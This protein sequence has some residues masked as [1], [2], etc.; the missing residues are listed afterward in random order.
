MASRPLALLAYFC[1][2]SLFLLALSLNAA[3]DPTAPFPGERRNTDLTELSLEELL[4]IEVT[5]VSRR[6]ELLSQASAAVHVITNDDIRRSGATTIPEALRLAPGVQVARVHAHQWAVSSRG[7][8]DVFANKLLVMIDGRSIYTPLF[9]GVFWDTHHAMLEDIE[10]IEVIRGPGASLWGANAVNGII[11]IITKNSR[12]TQGTLMSAAAGDYDQFVGTVR[13]GAQ[14]H[15]DGFLRVYLTHHEHDAFPSLNFP[16]SSDAWNRT[17][18]GFRSDWDLSDISSFTI[19]GDLYRGD[20]DEAYLRLSPEDPYEPF[21]EMGAIETRGGNLLGRVT[22]SLEHA[23]D[24]SFQIYYDRA[25]RDATIFIDDRHTMDVDFQHSFRPRDRHLLTWGAGYR[26][27]WDDVENTFDVALDPNSRTLQLFNFYLQDEVALVDEQVALT[28]GSKFEHNDFTGL[29]VQP[30]ARLSWT[31]KERQTVWAGI[32]RAVRTPSRAE[33]DI[34]LNQPPVFPEGAMGPGSPAMVTSFFGSGDFESEE[35]IAY[36]VGY[37]AQPL[38]RFSF[39]LA[40]FYNDYDSLRSLEPTDPQARFE[41]PPPHVGFTAGNEISG[42]TY[43]FEAGTTWHASG[44]WRLYGSYSL[45]RMDLR[46][47]ARSGDP[48]TV[49][50]TE[51]TNPRHQWLLRSSVDI[52]PE[53]EWDVGLRFV[54]ELPALGIDEYL[55][56]DM[57]LAWRPIAGLEAALVGSNLLN[58]RHEEFSPSFIQTQRTEIPRSFYAKLTWEF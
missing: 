4:A 38:D 15:E 24:V 7:F 56:M 1:R 17:Q 48:M 58:R 35:L 36:E 6:P 33:R 10:R 31:P 46:Q 57:R 53:M 14:L 16:G 26:L 13:H 21:V 8:N 32:A 20:L 50:S 19:Q 23:G 25:K 3:T 27:H 47:S 44:I 45:L 40:A 29:E 34:R 39:D 11:N 49:D 41:P 42:E 30:G 55:E 28:L 9:S 2:G 43:G 37:R 52:T 12:D 54:D 18:L 51:G 22:R 5:T